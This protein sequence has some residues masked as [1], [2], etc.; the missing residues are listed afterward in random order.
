[1]TSFMDVP[2]ALIIW[3]FDDNQKLLTSIFFVLQERLLKDKKQIPPNLVMWKT[4][5]LVTTVRFG[6]LIGTLDDGVTNVAIPSSKNH[7]VLVSTYIS[8]HNAHVRNEEYSQ[9]PIRRAWS[10]KLFWQKNLLW[11]KRILYQP[12]LLINHQF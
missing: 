4:N 1:M 3:S 5:I 6:V 12:N 8:D 7:I 10:F 9:V 11:L 2:I